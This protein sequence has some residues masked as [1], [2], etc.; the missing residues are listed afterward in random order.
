MVERLV[1]N[2]KVEGSTPFARSKVMINDK[3]LSIN[4]IFNLAIENQK[5]KNFQ[6]AK[7]LYSQI[8]K[9]NPN[10]HEVYNNLGLI[11]L[12]EGNNKEAKKFFKKAIQ[13]NP[14]LINVLYNLGLVLQKM[15][16]NEEAKKYY[17]KLIAINSSIPEA[18]NNLGVVQSN[19]GEFKEAI[20]NYDLAIKNNKN[21]SNAKENLI[22]S[23]TCSDS[24]NHNPIVF[25]NNSL[26][27]LYNKFTLHDLLKGK[28]LTTFFEK[29]N[30][31]LKNV[32]D[33]IK[34]IEFIETQ[35]YR[36]NTLDLDCKRHHR[37]FNQERIIPKFCFSCFKIQ[38]DPKN[39][40]DLIK[41]FFIFDDFK[42]PNNNWRK[43]MIEMRSDVKGTYKGFIYCSSFDE[44]K[45]ILDDIRPI[46][47][48]YI[49]YKI[50]IKRGCSEFYE[51]FPD[52]KQIDNTEDNFMN[53]KGYWKDIEKK[54]DFKEN[55][56]NKKFMNTLSGLSL[57]DLLIMNHWFNY[58]KLIDDLTYKKVS[59]NFISSKFIENRISNQIELRRK[60]FLC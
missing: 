40:I 6:V 38:I 23:L 58:A 44:A 57:S 54:A 48:K 2:E 42:F 36:R 22:S 5:K 1:A 17:K 15:G 13:I 33:N 20:N 18:Y 30:E 51:L 45:I 11:F 16:D 12:S 50:N 41:L 55:L 7:D 37:V 53:Y 21:F 26:K 27:K 10:S 49:K 39:I 47:E 14:N 24:D 8:L 59:K 4:A 35:T 28:N 34:D 46:L 29:C 52:F 19:L 43:C 9:L 31:I 25:A 32:N 60:E 3:K 56:N